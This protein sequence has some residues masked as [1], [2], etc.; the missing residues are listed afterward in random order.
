MRN[1]STEQAELRTDDERHATTNEAVQQ[2]GSPLLAHSSQQ[3][4]PCSSPYADM[5]GRHCCLSA[6]HP[7]SC[8]V[9]VIP[10]V[11]LSSQG[12]RDALADTSIEG[13]RLTCMSANSSLL[14][15]LCSCLTCKSPVPDQ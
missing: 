1:D 6:L 14:S 2:E 10:A 12:A 4:K 5:D 15:S 8:T 3:S 9:G 11:A 13:V 7:E